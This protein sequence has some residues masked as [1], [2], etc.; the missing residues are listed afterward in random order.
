MFIQ[1]GTHTPGWLVEGDMNLPLRTHRSTVHRYLV[2]VWIY[3]CAEQTDRFTVYRN[4]P[5]Q[6]VLL[7]S[8]AG[9]HTGVGDKL[10]QTNVQIR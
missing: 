10:L 6:N 4:A 2:P 5:G 1:P 8:T 3:F 9:S 7:A